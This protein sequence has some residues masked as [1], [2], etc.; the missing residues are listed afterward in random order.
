MNPLRRIAAIWYWLQQSISALAIVAM[1]ASCSQG[2]AEEGLPGADAP[3][4]AEPTVV[5]TSSQ[6][7][8]RIILDDEDNSDEDTTTE[9][10]DGNTN[11]VGTFKITYPTE[12]IA[13]AAPAISWTKPNGGVKY[14]LVVAKDEGCKVAVVLEQG[15][16]AESFQ[17]APLAHGTYY[18]CVYAPIPGAKVA[19]AIN[20]PVKF[21]I[22]TEA[23]TTPVVTTQSELYSNK[24]KHTYTWDAATDNLY[25]AGYTMEIGTLPEKKDILVFK[26]APTATTY[27][28]EGVHG[29]TYH[30]RVYSSDGAR[31]T[32]PHS[33]PFGV[34]H[35][36]NIPPSRP[37]TPVG[38]VS[39][40]FGK[41]TY[42]WGASQ[43]DG[44]GVKS[45]HLQIGTTPDGKDI[46]DAN[47]G[48]ALTYAIDGT[49][50]TTYY[51]KVMAIDYAGNMSQ[52]SQESP[53]ELVIK[54]A[55]VIEAFAGAH[56]ALDGHI[57]LAEIASSSGIVRLGARHYVTEEY[58]I[59]L[60]D[61]VNQICD[62][63]KTYSQTV[64][65]RIDTMPAV[66]GAYAVC[67]KLTNGP[68][69]FYGKSQVIYRDTL[70]PTFTSVDLANDVV[71]TF[72]NSTERLVANDLVANVVAANYDA[73]DYRII[74]AA[75]ACDNVLLTYGATVP[76]NDHNHLTADG[77]YKV[78]V[79]AADNA[80]NLPAFG[81]SNPFTFDT[82]SPAFTSIDLTGPA[83]D[84]YINV[85]ENAASN[86]LANNLVATGQNTVGYKLVTAVT[87]CDGA[88]VYGGAIPASD[89]ADFGADGDYKIC[90]ELVDEALNP[91]TY[92]ASNT[93]NI[94]RQPPVFTSI[95]LVNDAADTYLNLAETGNATAIVG[96][97]NAAGQT[98]VGYK[99][100]SSA[101]NCDTS[102]VYGAAV[103]DG[104]DGDFAADGPYKVCVELRDD[105]GNETYGASAVI[106]L[107]KTVPNFTS[108]DLANDAV[109]AYINLAESANANDLGAN[110]NGAGYD[111]AAYVLVTGATNCDGLL[112]YGVMPLSNSATF[113]GDGAYKVCIKLTDDAGNPAAYGAS[114]P[115]TLDKTVPSFTS[116]DLAND[117]TDTYINL[118]ETANANALADNLNGAGHDVAQ[119]KLVANATACDNLLVYGVMP[120]SD[121]AD[122]GLDGAYKVCVQ[123]TDNAGN[124]ADYGA[125]AA[126]A[127]DK[128]VPNFT[129]VDHA[130][131]ASDGY[132]NLAE[133]ANAND[134]INN[135]NATGYDTVAYI[136]VTG[137]TNCDGLL[138]YG[139][140]PQSNSA[141]FVAD[142]PYKVCVKLADDAGNPAD[143]GSSNPITLDKTVPNFTSIDLANDAADTYINL[144][145]TGNANDLVDNLTAT[146]YDT[147]EYK[148][149]ANATSCDNL[150]VYGALPQSNSGDFGA[151]GSYKVCVKITDTA[152][153]PADYGSS[154][155]MVLDKS[156][157]SFTSIDLA[158][159]AL[160][161]YINLVESG[162]SN[163][164]ATNL[165]ASN[166]DTVAYKLVTNATNC[167]GLLAYGA[168]PQSDSGDF[169]LDGGYK[170]CI[171]LTDDAGNP[172]DYGASAVVT[173]DKTVPSFTSI[174]LAN[175]AADTYINLA[176]TG[177]GNDLV[178]NLN[179][180]G[181]DTAE[182]KLVTG[183]TNCD[184]LLVYGGVPQSSAAEF[185]G[186]GPYKVC[187]KLSD[188]AGNPADYGN[189]NAIT[190]D[191][192]VPNYTSADLANDAVD[193]YINLS[194]TGNANPLAT[195]LVGTGYD[196]ATYKLVTNATAC[197]GALVYGAAIPQSD[198]GDFGVDGSYK[199]CIKLADDAGNPPDYG[200]T[201]VINL[202]KTVPD[203]T[204]IDLANDA[205]GGYINLAETGNANDLANNLVATGYDTAEYKLVTSAVN[206]DVALVYGAMPQSNSATF[207]GDGAYKICIKLTDNAGNPA[208][209][210]SSSAITLDKTVPS[211]TSVD[212]ANDAIGG[213]INAAENA[214]ANDLVTNLSASG[215]DTAS[216]KLVATATACDGA[217]VYGAAI[218][219]S[220]AADFGADGSYKVCVA[221]ADDAGN[222]TDYG[223][224]GNFLL[225]TGVPNFTSID[226]ANDAVGGYINLAESANAN[227]LLTNM[228]ASN[229]DSVGYKLV[230]AATAC[231]NALVYGAAIPKSNSG[232]FAVDGGYKVCIE[233]T[234]NAGNPADYGSSG[235]I[236]L[237]KTVPNFTSIDLANDATDG[238]INATE[239]ATAND[240]ADNL[241]GTGYDTAQ[242][243]LV[244]AATNCDVALTYG[245]AIPKSNAAEFVGPGS[246]KVCVELTDNAGN[247]TDY[248]GSGNVT[249]DITAESA[250]DAFG[251]ISHA[252]ATNGAVTVTFDFPAV[253]S[254]DNIKL[255]RVAG[256]VAPAD[257]SSGSLVTT[258]NSFVTDPLTYTDSEL[259]PGSAYSYLACIY[260]A[261][262]NENTD[263]TATNVVA[264]KVHRIFVTSGA[265][266]GNLVGAGGA[267]SLCQTAGD[268]ID[269]TVTWVALLSQ[270][271]DAA[272]V[273]I[274]GRVYNNNAAPDLV[275][276]THTD[277]WDGTLTNAIEYNES[278]VSVGAVSVW[279]GANNIGV[280]D[281]TNNCSGFSSAGAAVNG[282]TGV[283]NATTGSAFD[284]ANIPCNNSSQR[285]YCLNEIMP[286][287]TGFSVATGFGI[288]GDVAV[289]VDFPATTTLYDTVTVRRA[290]GGTPPA[291]ACNDGTLV[292][293]Y[294]SWTDDSFT[295]ATGV[296]AGVYSYRICLYDAD[297]LVGS[298]TT[299]PVIAKGATHK[300]FITSATY[301]G[302]QIDLA[303]ADAACDTIGDANVAAQ[304][305]VALLSDSANTLASR[306]DLTTTI[307]N[308]SSQPIAANEADLLDNALIYAIT[309]DETNAA[310]TASDRVWTGSG[311]NG[312]AAV[313]TCLDWL[314]N[315][316][317]NSGQVGS[318]Q[319]ATGAFLDTTTNTCDTNTNHIYCV[320][321]DAY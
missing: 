232:D 265:Y 12:Y 200:A 48:N 58:T 133:S 49:H 60:G 220:N 170:V 75:D 122:F 162:N 115:I 62:A 308:L 18:V 110:L 149:V 192:T 273:P 42:T 269:N 83:A 1:V 95:D 165:V 66:D 267:N 57:N 41:L 154:A 249:F 251:A 250:M 103:P 210:G 24:L 123:L 317:G 287:L 246:Y 119:Y 116:I 63:T 11:S 29:G 223:A 132:I 295:D 253:H 77:L 245:A 107:D 99:V 196:T 46:V 47:I 260:D 113:V 261:A 79:R 129:S 140:I 105:S 19:E 193:T 139:A 233:L 55:P 184:G 286:Q 167:D 209:Y 127:L 134:L 31:N 102:L 98:A 275:A 157:P 2:G 118:A 54:P 108:L 64:P 14:D 271:L 225:D 259:V 264:S 228:V 120:Q 87:V 257:C 244:T 85:A 198:S 290:S 294:N 199:V 25:L 126:I 6:T 136:L 169:G 254:Y 310:V 313:N 80:G 298:H 206:C 86:P 201:A 188:N 239:N 297:G 114:N 137:P 144:A 197:D 43:D 9:D 274:V 307:V 117:A 164:L 173:L 191:K 202:D 203:F 38:V 100:V 101:T 65:P 299:T 33:N 153:N 289:T 53:G 258:V 32:S 84:G 166:Y 160:D 278:E 281:S 248:G 241:V 30:A 15:I 73:I 292:K 315:T 163:D 181:H 222:P 97:L 268:T 128:T 52:F 215:H 252:A 236:T 208:D 150:L 104:T 262:G 72:L 93:F 263:G 319:S 56:E 301:D 111:T 309:Y 288:D 74:L 7:S 213:Y 96:N 20:S 279:L 35:I 37:L 138:A 146:G 237:D 40:S 61:G 3:V 159:D 224:S 90:I 5:D 152:G 180:A 321:A 67:V 34:I 282:A 177:N 277:F 89:S 81:A 8:K 4:P 205:A 227:D 45:Y 145:E 318:P 235:N 156:V 176:E 130:N 305:W 92:G 151:N 218:P 230:T 168:M 161:T 22:D 70:P 229:Y 243:K 88:L 44:F 21:T 316:A 125:S 171:K 276:N 303:T 207:V 221:V 190:L 112:A 302:S 212:L 234:D 175:D 148:L 68:H 16:K 240:L 71:D 211:F 185:V 179:A 270:T 306:V 231:T 82:I 69:V 26:V 314:D 320:S 27:E 312:A 186:D 189:S 304:T 285:L 266:T 300:V 238:Y 311:S 283:A 214:T 91:P 121:S 13:T 284:N 174:D 124:P 106:N 216:Y 256:A 78:C 296:A 59:I 76:T 142:G 158:N 109:D 36:D 17:L 94:D 39:G 183:A 143:Y 172:A 226:L 293:T 155:A 178:T 217:L 272:S 195:N 204:S 10:A 147:A 280:I 51:A 50:N 242:Y 255:R 28:L 23:P 141:T 135:L 291:A 131:D 247:P 194:E 187:V 219:K 182:Y